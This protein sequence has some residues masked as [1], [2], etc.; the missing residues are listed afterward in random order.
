MNALSKKQ[1]LTKVP[2]K[3]KEENVAEYLTDFLCDTNITE[4]KSERTLHQTQHR[5]AKDLFDW[6]EIGDRLKSCKDYHYNFSLF[7]QVQY[8]FIV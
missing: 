8:H 3:A 2:L 1:T 6:E 7:F 5:I 4:D